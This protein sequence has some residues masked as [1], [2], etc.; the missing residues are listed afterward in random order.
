[1]KEAAATSDGVVYAEVMRHLFGL[2][3]EERA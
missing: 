1:M 2:E 3:R